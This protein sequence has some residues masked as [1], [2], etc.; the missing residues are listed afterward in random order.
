M[1]VILGP[2]LAPLPRAFGRNVNRRSVNVELRALAAHVPPRGNDAQ[3]IAALLCV[4][5]ATSDP[6]KSATPP[7]AANA[8]M[9]QTLPWSDRETRTSP[10][11]FVAAS[12]HRK[13]AA[14]MA[15][16]SLDFTALISP[17]E[18]P[19][20]GIPVCGGMRE[21]SCAP[22]FPRHDRVYQFR[23]FD[24]SNMTS[25]RTPG[26]CHRIRSLAPDRRRGPPLARRTI[27]DRPLHAVIYTHSHLD[28]FGGVRGVVPDATGI[29]IIA[30]EGFMEHAVTENVIAGN[31]MSRRAQFQFGSGL[32][33]GPEGQM[34]SGIG[35][36]VSSGTFTLIPPTRS[37]AR[38]GE[39]LTV[40]GVRIEFQLTP[41]TEAQ[42]R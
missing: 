36:A 29:E 42:R 32:A 41:E 2:A 7:R 11:G 35:V 19:D 9:S 34:T 18:A 12:D 17:S 6:R 10:R 16:A 30:P 28:H 21:C 26:S 24:V 4:G 40:D 37:I 27:G 39:T 1:L 20:T 23:G 15:A 22:D 31:A 33:P 25:S 3:L 38:T 13:S 8:A 14:P 5:L